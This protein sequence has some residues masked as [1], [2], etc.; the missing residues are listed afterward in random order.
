MT[1]H[2]PYVVVG[3]GA[4]GLATDDSAQTAELLR[5]S[6]RDSLAPPERE[7]MIGCAHHAPR[8]FSGGSRF[9]DEPR[10]ERRMLRPGAVRR[11]QH[12][13]RRGYFL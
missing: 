1:E 2:V 10:P 11:P 9:L 7:T 3:A 13:F 12:P 4:M 6:L 8:G 5:V